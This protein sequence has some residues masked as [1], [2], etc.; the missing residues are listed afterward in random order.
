MLNLYPKVQGFM[1]KGLK[2]ILTF[3]YHFSSILVQCITSLAQAL[4]SQAE[5]KEP[6]KRVT[7]VIIP[8]YLFKINVFRIN[9]VNLI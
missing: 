9:R 8:K 5:N 4:T 2:D 3:I 6:W 1:F 7:I